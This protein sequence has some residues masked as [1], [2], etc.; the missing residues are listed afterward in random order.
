MIEVQ[1]TGCKP[2]YWFEGNAIPNFLELG[3][4]DARRLCRELNVNWRTGELQLNFPPGSP[5]SYLRS[6]FARYHRATLRDI[7]AILP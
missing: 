5:F 7:A 3:W 2:I 4:S 1:K 6:A